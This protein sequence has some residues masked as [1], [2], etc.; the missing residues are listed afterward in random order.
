MEMACG[1]SSELN[2]VG[3][4]VS[5]GADSMKEQTIARRMHNTHCRSCRLIDAADPRD[6]NPGRGELRK[7]LVTR[8]IR[9]HDSRQPDRHP[10]S[11][12]RVRRVCPVAT[13]ALGDGLHP[14]R[15]SP[16]EL[17][18]RPN[19][20]VETDVPATEHTCDGFD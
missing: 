3:L 14:G 13:H 18:D 16:S 5:A 11:R 6:F 4:D 8:G 7:D 15:S 19:R 20:H 2:I 9:T 1:D 12:E 10:K 17:L